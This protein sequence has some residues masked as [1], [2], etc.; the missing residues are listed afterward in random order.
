MNSKVLFSNSNEI[1]SLIESVSGWKVTH[2]DRL[3]IPEGSGD[4]LVFDFLFYRL[5]DQ[6]WTVSEV[7][8]KRPEWEHQILPLLR[9]KHYAYLFTNEWYLVTYIKES[10]K[11]LFRVIKSMPVALDDRDYL[12]G[13]EFLTFMMRQEIKRLIQ[14]A[15]YARDLGERLSATL[16]RPVDLGVTFGGVC[17]AMEDLLLQLNR[18]ISEWKDRFLL[19]ALEADE[20]TLCSECKEEMRVAFYVGEDRS[21]AL[22]WTPQGDWCSHKECKYYKMY[23]FDELYLESDVRE[24]PI[25]YVDSD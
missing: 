14:P 16:K 11:I 6:A 22:K 8:E 20:K 9:A 2:L 3:N 15:M 13:T 12:L 10:Y 7:L 25:E 21:Q 18:E 17:E 19:D 4:L 5:P 23:I 1:C 24:T